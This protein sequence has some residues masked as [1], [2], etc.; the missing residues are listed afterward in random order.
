MRV[1]AALL[2]I[3]LTAFAN[4]EFSGRRAP[5][6]CL[7]DSSFKR[8]DLQDYRGRWLLIDIMV[9]TCPHCKGL[10]KALEQVKAKFGDRLAILE[11]VITPPETQDTVAKYIADNGITAPVV[12]DQGQVAASYLDVTPKSPSF[13][14]PHLFVVDPDGMIVRDFGHSE[15]NEGL[16]EGPGLI[17]SLN[18]LVSARR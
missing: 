8:Y 5:G 12:F 7:P 10:S 3:A 6:F 17:R 16:F 18:T 11:I 14:T 1:A 2:F 15:E 4:N 13:N 9:T